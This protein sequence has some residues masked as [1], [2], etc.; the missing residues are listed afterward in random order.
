MEKTTNTWDVLSAIDCSSHTETRDS[1]D[2]KKLTY[3]S[4]AWAWGIV[5]E[6]YPETSYTV[7]E[8]DGKPY[9][10]DEMLGYMV[11]TSVTI[12]GETISMR[13]PVMDG[14]NKAMKSQA[15]EY[16]TRSGKKTVEPAT[17]R[18]INDA[19]MRCLTKNL[20]MF[21]L[22]HYIYAGEELPEVTKENKKD[23]V[24]QVVPTIDTEANLVNYFNS[25]PSV[26]KADKSIIE[27]F[28]KRK[29]E[30]QQDNSI[31]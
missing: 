5:R 27:Q 2:G 7:R 1:G 20:A 4:W 23:E 9:L 19:I 18:D 16:S 14:K 29:I 17:M 8:W 21:G 26:L 11:E 13:L 30:I 15:W 24:M 28:S 10:F 12:A 3:L 6:H 31:F 25:L 22:G